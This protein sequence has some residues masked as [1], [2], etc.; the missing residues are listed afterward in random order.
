MGDNSA[1]VSNAVFNA[2]DEY[3][4]FDIWLG[5]YGFAFQIFGDFAGYSSIARGTSLLFGISLNRNFHNP[6][7]AV[8]PSDFW[9]RWHISLS[10]WLRDYLYISLGGNR[11]GKLLTMRNLYLT[12]LLGGLWHGASW[13]FVLWGAFHGTI[14]VIYHSFWPDKKVE[15][16]GYRKLI[17]V[18][19]MFQLTC[20]S[21]ILFRVNELQDVKVILNQMIVFGGKAITDYV[22]LSK[23]NIVLF[24]I[25]LT[26]L[27][28]YN[29]LLEKSNDE[30]VSRNWN[31]FY[32]SVF[33]SFLF[34]MILLF[35]VVENF[36]FIYFQF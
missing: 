4:G 2:P 5:V 6:Y 36:E 22:F 18:F 26:S 14:L 11:K 23:F 12:M 31:W 30:F 1:I 24:A 32:K 21:W 7:F 34:G 15:R 25:L 33:A 28:G 27:L 3:Q 10:S 20:F 17:S 29:L 16:T 9:K 13:N 35:G 8:S 19:I